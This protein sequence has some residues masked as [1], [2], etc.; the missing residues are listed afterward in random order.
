MKA[1]VLESYGSADQFKIKEVP[2]PDFK[3]GQILIRNEASSVNPVDALVRSGSLKLA[4]G[5]FGPQIIGSDFSGTVVAT[6]SPKFKIGD[7][8]FGHVS[9]IT[10]GAYA[11]YVAVD[12]SVAALKPETISYEEAGSLSLV[13][14]TAWQGLVDEG[15]I[16]AGD[17][18]L[19][20]GCT[21]G[22]GSIAVQ[23]A[24]SWG[25]IV[26]GMCSGKNLETARE[27]GCDVVIDYE[28]ET[29]PPTEKYDLI[30]DAS[31]KFSFSE[32]K[33]HLKDDAY[34]VTTRPDAKDFGS[35]VETGID[36]LFRKQMKM[37]MA[38]PNAEDLEK[39]KLLLEDG[40]LKPL[41]AQTF[42]LEQIAQAH[43]KLEEGHFVGKV[44]IKIS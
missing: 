35:A 9:P 12:D 30:F 33:G 26:T 31:G 44:A 39:I 40:H 19:I 25:A 23:V 1:A 10:G 3:E 7:Q 21:G 15:K 13:A 8:V 22:V 2:T 34:Y 36:L 6:K 14:T 5:L 17:H 41:V 32:V 16:E 11:E 18:V 24:K 27:L 28:K 4:S 42:P 29:L 37:F 20:N 43:H 38:K